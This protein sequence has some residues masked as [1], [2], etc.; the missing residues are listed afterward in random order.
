MTRVSAKK[1]A[2][3]KFMAEVWRKAL[4]HVVAENEKRA[5]QEVARAKR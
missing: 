1:E 3:I 2:E 4:L 5:K